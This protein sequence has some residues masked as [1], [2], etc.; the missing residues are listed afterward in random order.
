MSRKLLQFLLQRRK[1]GSFRKGGLFRK[2][3]SVEVLLD[4]FVRV[5]IAIALYRPQIGPPALGKKG[6]KMAEKWEKLAEKWV[7]NGHFPISWPVFPPFSQ[8]GQNPFF[9]HFFPGPEA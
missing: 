1:K 4:S 9:G 8:W 7:K 5:A 3:H 2:V 6:G